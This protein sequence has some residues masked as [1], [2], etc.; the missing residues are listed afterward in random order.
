MGF[1][2]VSVIFLSC[3]STKKQVET[4]LEDLHGLIN[5]NDFNIDTDF[6]LV[7]KRKQGDDE[8]FSTPFTLLDLGYDASDVVKRL[9]EL[10]VDEYSE[11]K[12]DKDD[13][14]PLALF[15]FGKVINDRLVYIK[16]K[17]KENQRKYVLCVSF[18]YA[19]RDMKFPY[20]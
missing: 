2:E 5:S 11:T 14:N 16:L 12:I 9:R 20:A 8:K 10:V 15:V 1:R 4:F 3:Q 19:K 18:H 7:S 17:I 6:V 13:V